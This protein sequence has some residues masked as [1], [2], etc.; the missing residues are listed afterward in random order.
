MKINKCPFNHWQRTQ[1]K[2]YVDFWDIKS[3]VW[4]LLSNQNHVSTLKEWFLTELLQDNERLITLKNILELKQPL[5]EIIENNETTTTDILDINNNNSSL[6]FYKD[7]EHFSELSWLLIEKIVN[8]LSDKLEDKIDVIEFV[9]WDIYSAVNQSLDIVYNTL[10]SSLDKILSEDD[11]RLLYDISP[12]IEWY[13]MTILCN[14]GMDTT[15]EI[16]AWFI[17]ELISKWLKSE[18]VIESV[19]EKNKKWIIDFARSHIL[20]AVI[21]KISKTDKAFI[22]DDNLSLKFNLT[23]SELDNI[24]EWMREQQIE[25]KWCPML[26]S[27]GGIYDKSNLINFSIIVTKLILKWI[28]FEAIKIDKIANK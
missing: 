9:K 8:D 2:S 23:S 1:E 28:D 13:F 10:S 27:K 20:T 7:L 16:I 19:L 14:Q 18:D 17:D 4:S 15:H 26:Y 12:W 22:F 11:N 6:K 25:Y 5:E 21:R 3:K 24:T